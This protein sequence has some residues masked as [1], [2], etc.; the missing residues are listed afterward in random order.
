MLTRRR[1][2]SYDRFTKRNHVI[3]ASV[4]TAML[5]HADGPL[6]FVAEAGKG[7][8]VWGQSQIAFD[9]EP[10]QL[11]NRND[12]FADQILGGRCNKQRIGP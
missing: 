7:A 4:C 5:E 6:T 2:G 3:K 9:R 8:K 10:P 11:S 12:A 1:L